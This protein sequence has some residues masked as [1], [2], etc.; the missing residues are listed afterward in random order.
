VPGGIV[1]FLSEQQFV[2]FVAHLARVTIAYGACKR[3]LGGVMKL[4]LLLGLIS[5]LALAAE[6][7][8]SSGGQPVT[9]TVDAAR[10]TGNLAPVWRFFGSDYYATMKDGRKLAWKRKAGRG[11]TRELEFSIPRQGVA[12]VIFA[13][14]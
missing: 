5:S 11:G 13:A 10:V 4:W 12:L 7:P 14:Q 1:Q 9:I 3:S 2:E 6:A 8:S